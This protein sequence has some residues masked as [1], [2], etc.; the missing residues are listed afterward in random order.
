MTKVNKDN[1]YLYSRYRGRFDVY[2]GCVRPSNYGRGRYAQFIYIRNGKESSLQCDPDPGVVHHSVVWLTERND[3]LA[4]D[5][6]V[7]HEE[8]AIQA[9]RDKIEH[10]EWNI[11]QIM[12]FAK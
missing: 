7:K 4:R 3:Q 1:V 10:H 11:K 9:L 2:Q 5:V 8:D 12:E 6:F